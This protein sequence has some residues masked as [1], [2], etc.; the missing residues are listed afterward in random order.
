VGRAAGDI[1]EQRG[2]LTEEDLASA[3]HTACREVGAAI[4]W[5][6]HDGLLVPRPEATPLTS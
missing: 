1:G 6:E 4:D 3:D 2:G 5:L